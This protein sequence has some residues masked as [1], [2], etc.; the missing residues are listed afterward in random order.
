M[1]RKEPIPAIGP[2]TS[3]YPGTSKGA[4]AE[5]NDQSHAGCHGYSTR[6][7]AQMLTPLIERAPHAK[8]IGRPPAVHGGGIVHVPPQ[9]AAAGSVPV[10]PN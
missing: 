4:H 3:F 5:A 1:M 8:A 6:I 2:K 9:S 10:L 7:A